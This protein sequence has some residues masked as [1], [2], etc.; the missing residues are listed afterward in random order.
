MSNPKISVIVPVYN[1]E[2][3]LRCCVDSILAQ[4]FTD[5]ELLLIKY[6]SKDMLGFNLGIPQEFLYGDSRRQLRL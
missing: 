1:D 2:K 5:F 3:Y 6:G 4:T